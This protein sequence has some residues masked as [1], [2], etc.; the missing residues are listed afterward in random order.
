[1]KYKTLILLGIGL[2]IMVAMLYVIGIDKVIDAFKLANVWFVLLAVAMQIFT[3]YLFAIRWNIV[4]KTANINIGIKNLL[5][6][7]LVGMAI[8]NTTPSGRIGGEPVKAYL[9]SKETN[10]P[11]EE[12]F[13][14]VIADRALDTFPFILL[15]V[16]SIIAMIYTFTLST[17]VL[18]VLII[19]VVVMTIAFFI[20]IYMSINERAGEKIK[21]WIV[22]LVW[23]FYKKVSLEEL[24]ERVIKA[25]SGFQ[26]T[27]YSML[28]DKKIL[29]YALPLSFLIWVTEILRVFLI[30]LAFG[31]TVDPIIIGVVFIVASLVGMI[32]LLPGGIGAVD[33]FMIVFYSSAGIPPSISAA[34][35]IIERMISF[36]MTSTIG[37]IILSHYGSNIIDKINT[38]NINEEKAAKEIIDELDYID[39]K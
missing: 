36:G 19:S 4:N 3:Y 15:A 33:G 27:M 2:A 12:A 25:I 39:E 11:Y 18:L 30:F 37:L 10:N 8:N 9:L 1:M 38:D 24:E 32:P 35:T 29:Y 17:V 6:M 14:T 26:K 16:M 23:L 13:A 34:V 22:K 28:H 31:A 20:V 21:K 5:A 7:T